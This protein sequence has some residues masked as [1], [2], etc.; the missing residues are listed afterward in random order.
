MVCAWSCWPVLQRHAALGE[1][2]FLFTPEIESTD[3]MLW[4]TLK[5]VTWKWSERWARV[6][7]VGVQGKIQM[8]TSVIVRAGS[9]SGLFRIEKNPTECNACSATIKQPC[10]WSR[11]VKPR[12]KVL[13]VREGKM[14]QTEVAEHFSEEKHWTSE[15]CFGP[16]CFITCSK[17]DGLMIL[18]T[19]QN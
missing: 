2:K 6:W 9:L 18:L 19:W 11:D 3:R 5:M 17:D 4:L 12:A 16:L 10:D 15:L 8:H 7:I 14:E 1:N 13:L